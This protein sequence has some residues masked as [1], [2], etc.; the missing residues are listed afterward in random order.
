MCRSVLSTYC[1]SGW[2]H[3]VEH[4]AAESNAYHKINGKPATITADVTRKN[5]TRQ[6][7][8]NGRE[9]PNF[10]NSPTIKGG[11]E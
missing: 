1:S 9:I 6:N 3:A 10:V 11:V 5:F 7:T 8:S 2:I 4:V